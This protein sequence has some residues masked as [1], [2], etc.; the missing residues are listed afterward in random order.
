MTRPSAARL[1]AYESSRSDVARFV[2]RGAR[3]ILELGCSTGALAAT[4][5]RRQPTRITGIELDPESAAI[6]QQRIDRVVVGDAEA[7]LAGGEPSLGSFDCLIAADVL[8]H[9]VDPWTALRRAV[10]LLEPSAAVVVSLPNVAYWRALWRIVHDGR[11]PRDDSGIFDRTHLRWFTRDDAVDLLAQAGLEVAE[12]VPKY[13][14]SGWRL[15][16][17]GALGRTRLGAHLAAQHVLLATR[18]ADLPI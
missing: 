2:P 13:W 3:R 6:A 17:Y 18:S 4:L 16:C 7:V 5:A 1:H 11:W 8:E 14:A 10:A 12:V 15:R 9:M